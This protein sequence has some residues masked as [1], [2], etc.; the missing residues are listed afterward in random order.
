M[1]LEQRNSHGHQALIMLTFASLIFNAS[2]T[3]SSIILIDKFG[4]LPSRSAWKA[5]RQ[6]IAFA[7]YNP[8]P[9]NTRAILTAY[10][11][12]RF[13]I[14][15]QWHCESGSLCKK[16]TEPDGYA[17]PLGLLNLI[18]GCLCICTQI[19][20]YTWLQHSLW[21]AVCATCF[22]AWGLIPLGL[23]LLPLQA[24]QA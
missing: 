3:I 1:E 12:D 19:V 16:G 24:V 17:L 23:I 5:S 10:G 14:L 8:I 20:L 13:L 2:A 4:E 7:Q 21:I 6:D 22:V 18:V 15:I 11:A 9:S